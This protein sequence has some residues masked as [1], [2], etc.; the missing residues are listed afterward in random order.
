MKTYSSFAV[1]TRRMFNYKGKVEALVKPPATMKGNILPW[2]S[3]GS[4]RTVSIA[5][6][7]ILSVWAAVTR[8]SIPSTSLLSV[9]Y[10]RRQEPANS[11]WY[12]NLT[13]GCPAKGEGLTQSGA[14]LTPLFL[15]LLLPTPAKLN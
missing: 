4:A 11:P 15:G 5:P 3:L 6:V 1:S 10:D 9:R 2:V 13:L 14:Q 7:C 12:K 8:P